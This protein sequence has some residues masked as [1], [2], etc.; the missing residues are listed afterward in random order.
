MDN[1][2]IFPRIQLAR[3]RAV[4]ASNTVAEL[5]PTQSKCF[6]KLTGIACVTT[7]L[8][9]PMNADELIPYLAT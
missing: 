8:L 2:Q 6:S 1:G 7:D 5:A 3:G 9:V 4:E